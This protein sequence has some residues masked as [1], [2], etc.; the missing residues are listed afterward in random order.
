MRVAPH[1][2]LDQREHGATEKDHRQHGPRRIEAP[3]GAESGIPPRQRQPSQPP[4]ATNTRSAPKIARQDS[5]DVNAP[6]TTG[7]MTTLVRLDT[8]R[9]LH[10]GPNHGT[11]SMQW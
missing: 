5:H 11:L 1:L 8:N 2:S 4:A 3:G 9:M 7:P 6:P 10:P